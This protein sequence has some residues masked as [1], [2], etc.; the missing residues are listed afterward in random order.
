MGSVGSSIKKAGR[1]YDENVTQKPWGIVA[2][3]TGIAT[4][5]NMVAGKPPSG[6]DA[7]ALGAPPPAP[8]LSDQVI[9]QA[10]ERER[11]RL[12]GGGTKA[13]FL[14]GAA[15]DQSPVSRTVKA[16]LGS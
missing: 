13:S 3:V 16:M 9:L 2:P 4:A 5:Y 7:G 10:R 8:T 14:T 6:P 1:W 11:R 12:M 15:G